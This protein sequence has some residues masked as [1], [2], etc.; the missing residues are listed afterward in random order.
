MI[1]RTVDRRFARFV[2]MKRVVT[3]SLGLAAGMATIAAVAA[4]GGGPLPLVACALLFFFGGGA[5]ALR[6]GL[7]LLGEL[8]R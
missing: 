6:D 7:R 8:K 1:G 4:H 2:A 3:G 5:W